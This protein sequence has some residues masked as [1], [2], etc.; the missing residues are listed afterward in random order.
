M[1]TEQVEGIAE[2]VAGKAQG[3]LGKLVGDPAVEAEGAGHEAAGQLKETYGDALDG[4][5]SFVKENP[6]AALAIG[7]GIGIL[8]SRLLRR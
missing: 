8:I 1:K 3:A 6:I 7:A 5:T 4:V 2:K